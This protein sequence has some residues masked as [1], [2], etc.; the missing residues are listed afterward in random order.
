MNAADRE[1]I[2]RL[3]AESDAALVAAAAGLDDEGARRR[4]EPERWS[5]LE[6]VE[7]VILVED[8]VFASIS[9]KST[10]GAP[11]VEPRREGQILRGMTN[12]ERKIPAPEHAEPTGRYWP[13]AE[14][15]QAFRERR[16]RTVAYVEQYQDDPRNRTTLHPVLG[17][18]NCQEMFLVL[19]LHPARHAL[20]IREARKRLGLE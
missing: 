20:Q 9:V 3:M 4:P 7:H 19:A 10:P 5:V 12:R 1:Q 11:A 18:V 15:L 16:A 13:L 2:L 14:A 17:P 8:G 6:C